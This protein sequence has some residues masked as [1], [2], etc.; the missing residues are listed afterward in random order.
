MSGVSRNRRSFVK[1]LAIQKRL[2]IPAIVSGAGVTSQVRAIAM[3]LLL[4]VRV[5]C[6]LQWHNVHT[7]F[8]KSLSSGLKIGKLPHRQHGNHSNLFSFIKKVKE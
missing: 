7:K 8:R 5:W 2:G 6:G 3:L 4:I 1:C